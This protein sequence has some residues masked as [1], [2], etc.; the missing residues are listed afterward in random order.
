MAIIALPQIDGQE[1]RPTS[2][3]L[4]VESPGQVRLETPAG[5]K[6][7]DVASPRFYAD[8]TFPAVK[9]SETRRMAAFLDQLNGSDNEFELRVWE[10]PTLPA[11][12]Q[13]DIWHVQGASALTGGYRRVQILNRS[14]Q[15][16]QNLWKIGDIIRIG[17]RC[18]RIVSDTDSAG[19]VSIYP[20]I[21]P[22]A[23]ATVTVSE[24]MMILRLRELPSRSYKD[25]F[26]GG[27]W[28]LV[29]EEVL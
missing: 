8:V 22:A 6:T 19:R 7:Y 13:A 4:S 11:N 17:T 16:F 26:F 3:A 23:G 12:R 14:N 18:A 21:N 9:S 27:P 5:V 20:D 24:V 25:N 28:T 15:A 29:C 10:D 1:F 2:I